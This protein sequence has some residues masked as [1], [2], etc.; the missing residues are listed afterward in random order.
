[1]SFSGKAA[2]GMR[3]SDHEGCLVSDSGE[4]SI[5]KDLRSALTRRTGKKQGN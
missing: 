4:K 3:A 1:M 5:V 2:N